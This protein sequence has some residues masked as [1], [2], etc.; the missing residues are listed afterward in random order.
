MGGDAIESRVLRLIAERVLEV[1]PEF[2][3]E[4]DLFAAGLD[5]MAIMQLILALEEAFGQ[6]IPIESVSRANFSSVRAVA[7]FVT[8]RGIGSAGQVPEGGGKP[9]PPEPAPATATEPAAP[10]RRPVS[11][12]V[13]SAEFS[14]LPFR[15]CDYFVWSFDTH[16][17]K[18][19]QGGHK[20]HSFLELEAVPDVARLRE[21]L[22]VAADR[23]P[24]MNALIRRRS[25]FA[26]PSWVPPKERAVPELRLFSEEGSPGRLMGEGG[27]RCG[28][29]RAVMEETV[30]TPMPQATKSHWPKAR[31]T[32]IERKEGGATLIFSWSH[33]MMD[34]VG[35]EFFLEELDRLSGAGG[36]PIRAV[37]AGEEGGAMTWRQRWEVARP[38]VRFFRS[39]SQRP[40]D[41]L[42]P[43]RPRPGR[44]SFAVYPLTEEETRI[45]NERCAAMGSGLVNMPF[46]LA[47]VA[48]AHHRVMEGR[49]M[50]PES[51]VC[52]V[53]VQIRRKGVRGPM[54][55]NHVTMFFGVLVPE[56]VGSLERSVSS[57]IAQ[58]A[59]FL[60][61]R[62]GEALNDL[63][64]SM[65]VIPPGLYM[66]FISMQMR[67]PFASFFHSHTG[68]FAPGMDRFLG[69]RI[70]G[71]Y[72]VPGIGT[73]PGTGIFFNEKNGR[74]VITFC[75]HEGA[76]TDEERG[77]MLA[78][79]L[80]DLGVA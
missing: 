14:E 26:R 11:E 45:T 18:T 48:R 8:A 19:G 28:D 77:M 72:H 66:K 43:R 53:P 78:Q 62:L 17:R 22:A 65:S 61:N 57:L 35:A 73:P 31:F 27:I 71:A 76:V 70:T 7:A 33:M 40:F 67:G 41:C 30:N 21:V 1:A 75:W 12:P 55:Q 3:V 25:F 29:V 2:G 13:D 50:R 46:Y 69:V 64:Q 15:G 51:H 56:E 42:G 54:F 60:K 10:P 52:S 23:H 37:E 4:S 9:E 5:S 20:A 68:E 79:L 34:G 32:L 24:M 16:S 49:G 44:T 47:C 6:S 59:S 63:M 58:H 39:M 80:G 74:L 38:M 36:E